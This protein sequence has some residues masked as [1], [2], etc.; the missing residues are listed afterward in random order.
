MSRTEKTAELA[1]LAETSVTHHE[2]SVPD[3]QSAPEGPPGMMAGT[4]SEGIEI[5]LSG[6]GT[7]I[8]TNTAVWIPPP[9]AGAVQNHQMLSLLLS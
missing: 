2:G 7:A 3:L 1:C 8:E 9:S 4:L 5:G 6:P